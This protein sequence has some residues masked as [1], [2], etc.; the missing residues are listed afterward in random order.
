ML[1]L[2]KQELAT[3]TGYKHRPQQKKALALMGFPFH[4]NPCGDI[5]VFRE[6][7]LDEKK[8]RASG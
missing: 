5:I 1:I 8:K 4:V 2:S 7:V 6:D 3:I